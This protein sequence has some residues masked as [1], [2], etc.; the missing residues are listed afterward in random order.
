MWAHTDETAGCCGGVEDATRSAR[1]MSS[2]D[3]VSYAL[4]LVGAIELI[5]GAIFVFA[6]GLAL[7]LVLRLEEHDLHAVIGRGVRVVVR[8]SIYGVGLR[9]DGKLGISV[10]CF[11]HGV[12]KCS[13]RVRATCRSVWTV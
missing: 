2:M 1:R 13:P 6:P 3:S 5:V 4:L 10:G 8:C 9:C 11:L 7:Q 12:E